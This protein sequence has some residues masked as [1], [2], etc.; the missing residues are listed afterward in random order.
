[1]GEAQKKS[2]L[3]TAGKG[4]GKD[5]R[6][7][8]NNTYTDELFLGICAPIGSR[9][10][11]VISHLIKLLEDRYN[12]VVKRIKLSDFID[13]HERDGFKLID[14]KTEAY[15][16]LRHKIDQGNA[17]RKFYKNKSVLV[18]LGI[19]EIYNERANEIA[20]NENELPHAEDYNSRRVCYIF[21]SI[22]NKEELLLLK[23]IYTDLFYTFSIFSPSKEREE[24]LTEKHLSKPEILE[25]ID[26]D[27]YENNTFGQ[28][29]RNTFT[30]G[31]FFLRVS[32]SNLNTLEERIERFL[33]LIF[34]SDIVTPFPHESAMYHAKSVA[35]NSSCL[36]RQVG[37]AITDEKGTIISK[38]W[39]DV[40]KFGG[41]L[42]QEG[43][44]KDERCK[45]KGH[46]SNDR[47][48]D[49]LVGS[50]IDFIG[51][52]ES[53]K[54]IF[55]NESGVYDLTIKEKLKNRLRLSK[56]KDLLEFSRS[57][58]AEMH[59][60]ITGSQLTGD[61][62]VGGKLFCTTYPCH[63]C[64]RHIIVAGIKEVYYIEPY[65]KSMCLHLH[66]DAI[67]DDENNED[68]VRVL[69]FDGVA[70]NKYLNFFT[71]FAE[72]K[73][74]KGNVIKPGLHEVKPKMAKTF[75]ALSTLEEQAIHS[76][77]ECGIKQ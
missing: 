4:K 19:S 49:T 1:M 69:M 55:L 61:E 5:S 58:H 21:D 53:L 57:V 8:V 47:E 7:K 72:R 68:K 25:I 43:D 10:E 71:K 20:T 65:V 74:K 63:N 13:A 18:E 26:T 2:D 16:R 51:N 15:S 11:P 33:H 45:F 59:A 27:E 70:P 37:A 34:E 39:N 64:A 75:Q 38:G 3:F 67:T 28:N 50:I 44:D 41:N 76:L 77:A 23:A 73:D 56:I 40:P 30:E 52:D 24:N 66:N 14:G 31:D 29:V 9:K 46:C 36:S 48:K 35:G 60:I 17:I 6:E 62:M 54:S 32:Q 12:Y 22:K 42:Y